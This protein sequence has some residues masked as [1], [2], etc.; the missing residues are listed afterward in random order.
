MQIQSKVQTLM[1]IDA[2]TFIAGFFLGIVMRGVQCGR[3]YLFDSVL[4]HRHSAS[5]VEEKTF[6]GVQPARLYSL[7][8]DFFRD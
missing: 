8:C 5:S 1:Y 4:Q 6:Y 7:F 3:F 2:A